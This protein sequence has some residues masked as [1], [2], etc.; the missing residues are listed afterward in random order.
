MKKFYL[1]VLLST[2]IIL[3]SY[4]YA[5]KTSDKQNCVKV[6]NSGIQRTNSVIEIDASNNSSQA[7][8]LEV[9]HEAGY[10]RKEVRE[11][12][13]QLSFGATKEVTIIKYTITNLGKKH[14]RIL[15]R[16]LVNETWSF[17]K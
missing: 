5:Q 7:Q 6:Y 14:R 3:G 1:L 8:N 16:D 13:K 9:L 15:D 10:F 4:S 11:E 2:S 12:I 17:C